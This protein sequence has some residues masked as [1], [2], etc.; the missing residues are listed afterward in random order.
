MAAGCSGYR[1]PMSDAAAGEP[2][3]TRAPGVQDGSPDAIRGETNPRLGNCTVGEPYVLV[4]GQDEML[5]RFEPETFSLTAV[6]AVRCGEG[7]VNS[8][9]TTP[10]GP[11]Y[12]SSDRGDL[13]AIDMKTL[14]ITQTPFDSTLVG[15]KSYGM[16]LLPDDSPAGQSLYVAGRKADDGLLVLSRIDLTTYAP[17]EIGSFP[18][19]LLNV[20]LTLGPDGGL[21]GLAIDLDRSWLVDIDPET[22]T[23]VDVSAVSNGYPI[24]AFA[25]VAW[26]EGFYFFLRPGGK[27]AMFYYFSDV[28]RYRLGDA[29]AT[30]VGTFGLPI[31]GA[32]VAVCR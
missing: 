32:G 24:S 25:L 4:L 11:V 14:Q 28:F 23:T 6:T 21:F 3:D 12:F 16:A 22:G 8:M 5:Y 31:V 1:S 18:P 26:Q 7:L 15:R 30:T 29:E 19:E 20:E 17:T 13:C 10:R 9:T 27:L 2:H